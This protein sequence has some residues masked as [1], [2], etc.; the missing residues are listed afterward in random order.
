MMQALQQMHS[1]PVAQG[2]IIASVA[3][4]I[5][6]S[7][8]NGDNKGTNKSRAKGRYPEK[9]ERDVDYATLMQWKKF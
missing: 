8:E 9:L 4:K 3:A 6:G 7:T 5:S 2:E 1:Q